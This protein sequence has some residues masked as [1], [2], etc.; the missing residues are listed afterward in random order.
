M[1]LEAPRRVGQAFDTD[2]LVLNMGPQHPSIP[3]PVAQSALALEPK[4]PGQFSDTSAPLLRFLP[5]CPRSAGAVTPLVPAECPAI[6][7]VYSS[8]DEHV[9]RI[10]QLAHPSLIAVASV[11]GYFLEMARAVLAPAIGRRH[12]MDECLMVGDNQDIPHVADL[13]ICD[14]VTYR[15]LRPEYHASQVIHHS[16]VSSACLDEI[17]AIMAN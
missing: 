5:R 17:A 8:A 11:S 7:I 4:I 13:I 15:L 3:I 12:S 14:S 9:A 6:R 1:T 10:R 2:E 16:L